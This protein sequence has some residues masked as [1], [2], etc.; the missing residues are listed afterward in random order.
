M[1]TGIDGLCHVEV[2]GDRGS[3][4]LS[5]SCPGDAGIARTCKVVATFEPILGR[6]VWEDCGVMSEG[7][8]ALK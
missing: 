7:L 8:E 1:L 4:T 2:E 6:E 5:S 3:D